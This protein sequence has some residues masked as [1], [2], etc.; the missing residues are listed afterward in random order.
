MFEWE[1]YALRPEDLEDEAIRWLIPQMLVAE[2]ITMFYGPPGQGKTWLMYALTRRL[3]GLDSVKKVWYLDWDNPKRQLKER[4]IDLL[5]EEAGERLAYLSKSS[6]D[7]YSYE[8]L[9][10]IAAEAV[11]RRYDG[12]VFIFST[13][14]GISSTIPKVMSKPSVLWSVSNRCVT[15]GRRSC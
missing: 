14:P 5:M 10:M 11:G 9:E 7:L 15:P 6:T 13:R 4:R 8:L 1:R 12:H 2:A 3:C